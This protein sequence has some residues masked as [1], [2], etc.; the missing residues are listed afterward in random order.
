MRMCVCVR[1]CVRVHAHVIVALFTC[2]SVH[3]REPD[4]GECLRLGV[5]ACEWV[6]IIID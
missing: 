3:S 1:A 4:V 5:A 6:P 2:A